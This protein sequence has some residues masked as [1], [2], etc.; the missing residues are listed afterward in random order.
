MLCEPALQTQINNNNNNPWTK[1]TKKYR[2]G[3]PSST[4]ASH[5]KTSAKQFIGANYVAPKISLKTSGS[6]EA[7][8]ITPEKGNDVEMDEAT[9]DGAA[10]KGKA[11]G[12]KSF[13]KGAAAVAVSRG[14]EAGADN[15]SSSE[16]EE[17]FNDGEEES[18]DVAME[19]ASN[20]RADKLAD[21]SEM[22]KSGA[23]DGDS[24]KKSSN[25]E[26]NNGKSDK[27]SGSDNNRNDAAKKPS[28]DDATKKEASPAKEETT[29][30]IAANYPLLVGNLS[31]SSR[32]SIRRH[33]LRGNWSYGNSALTPPQRFELIRIIPPEETLEDLPKDG[34]FDGSFNVQETVTKKK[35]KVK[36]RNRAIV[37]SGVK[38]TFKEKGKGGEFSVNGKGANEYGIFELFGSATKNREE[39]GDDPTY[40]VSVHKKYVGAPPAPAASAAKKSGE[41]K[42][43]KKRKHADTASGDDDTD[44][45]PPT[46]LP[47]VGV[48]L[49]G[50]LSRNT[51]D[52]LSLD[53]TAVHKITG[54]WSMKGLSGILEEP[55]VCEKFE[56]EHKTTGD[57]TVFPLSGRYTGSFYVNETG[58]RTKI[59]ERDVT[60]KFK[61]NL[62]G[63]HNVEGK[64]SNIY[65]K[66]SITGTLE[67][68]G[69]ITLFR[70][71]A[72]IKVKASKKGGGV[73]I[74]APGSN[75]S[76]S[77]LPS[78]PKAELAAV[79]PPSALLTFDDVNSPE[80]DGPVQPLEPPSQFTATMRG[81]LKIENDGT[82]TCSG[83][84]AMSHE[85]FQSGL[86][87]KYHFGIVADNAA[88]DATAMLDRMEEDG[89]D[90]KDDRRL[91]NMASDGVSPVTPSNSTFPIDSTQYKGSFKLRKGA[92]RTQTIVDNQ[93]V[94]KYVKNSGGSYN[95]YGKGSNE[96]GTFDLVGTLILQGKSNGLMQ[97]Y[98]MYPTALEPVQQA[99][100]KG[101]S[102]VFQGGL[103]EKA[104]PANSAPAPAMKPPERF[105]PS[106]SGLQRRESSRMSRLPSR[107]EEDD[108]Q[109]QMDRLMERCR[110]ILK[111]LNVSDV[112][113]IFAVPVDPI[114]LG[115][116]TYFDVI[117]EP[118][119]LGTIQTR[120]DNDE[121]DTPDEF[122][123]L[124]RLTL[125]NAITFNTQ[126]DNIVH[127]CARNLSALFNKKFGTIDKSWSAAQ[128]NRKLTK[129][130][131]LEVKRKEKD[132]AKEVKK[133][134]KEEKERKRKAEVEASNESKRMK[135]ENVLAANRSTMA[136]I[137]RA[138]PEDSNAEMTREE[139]NLLVQAIKQV[140]DQIVGLHK[141]VK[142][143]SSKPSHSA[144]TVLF[145][146]SA[147]VDHSKETHS[148]SE[149]LSSHST[150]PPKKKKPKKEQPPPDD[151]EEEYMPS[152]PKAAPASPMVEDLQP[153]SF[154]EQ[155]ALSDSINLLP[156][157]LLPGAMQ[158]I[159]EADFVNDDDDEI[160]LD[161]DQLDTKT[162]RKLQ[163]F[164]MEN[165]KQKKPKKIPKKRQPK[166]QKKEKAAAAPA[167]SPEAPPSP[168]PPQL[169]EGEEEEES[170]PK[171]RAPGGN[172][173]KSLFSNF[174]EDDSDDDDNDD[175]DEDLGDFQTD[176]L[177]NQQSTTKD[178]PEEKDAAADEK[179]ASDKGESDKDGDGSDSEPDL[180]GAAQEEA[181]AAKAREADRLKREEKI[182]QEAERNK[183]KRLEEAAKKGD[184][185]IAKRK[186]QEAAEARRLEEEERKAEEAREKAREAAQKEVEEEAPTIDIGDEQRK[187]MEEFEQGWN[188]N[189]SAGGASPAS[190]FG[191]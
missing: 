177:G 80:G 162:Q 152:S 6:S 51:S 83:T 102:K 109:A 156:E 75:G 40:K 11:A 161:I 149:M 78:K 59:L 27:K 46:E 155:E 101:S 182:L 143:Q 186:E 134:A 13:T 64:G 159:R 132:A 43:D 90:E 173:G 191:F 125:N 170:K 174:G 69:M 54:L 84:W 104:T 100:K 157:R 58:E 166:N 12:G 158:I 123:R 23:K 131:R 79:A 103:T 28:S 124:V 21:A 141:L 88:D 167:A 144:P 184:E 85:H 151:E 122:A 133:K 56:Y 128:K 19:D 14:S 73:K 130:E 5:Q 138:A 106:M 50:K 175:D 49:R 165:V 48:T 36:T 57:S 63:Y 30:E 99:S 121:I 188:D 62:A 94:L 181:K 16:E 82:H 95:V 180:W 81:I 137:A 145:A 119:D 68:D 172:G 107:L 142:K 97:L 38:L 37:E 33:I 66:Y 136:A 163:Q 105:I 2:S 164:V 17:E 77:K 140:Q 35:G 76:S 190:D 34:V 113:K 185:I 92:T 179:A 7:T 120:L 22:K 148:D 47:A 74:A 72:P 31:Y 168:P 126:P 129:A 96:M 24:K 178:A 112:Q 93:I 8:S 189:Y 61:R 169:E 160:D 10:A 60:L 114:T 150:K 87:S 42:K 32:E 116:P 147:A 183:Q 146:A 154:E 15:H 44:L 26:G 108:P 41:G 135:L 117:A 139:Y 98:R 86:T 187:I 111:E 127:I 29:E 71:F 25:G 153:L 1:K 3:A 45:P 118:M 110:Q 39:D 9:D 55:D 91:K 89:T 115:I 20:D 52:E 70:H 67:K 18:K 171:A 176:W 53:N 4:L 65:G